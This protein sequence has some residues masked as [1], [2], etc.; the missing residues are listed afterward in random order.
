MSWI[1]VPTLFLNQGK[2]YCNR[3]LGVFIT[4]NPSCKP[5]IRSERL[6]LRET[7]GAIGRL[8]DLN[9]RCDNCRVCEGEDAN[10]LAYVLCDGA[11]GVYQAY[12]AI[13]ISTGAH[14]YHETWPVVM[15]AL[16]ERLWT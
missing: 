1:V 6:Q 7:D 11:K 9:D 13:D 10:F 14:L 3:K 4:H 16:F 2:I 15:G 12:I 8:L 5:S